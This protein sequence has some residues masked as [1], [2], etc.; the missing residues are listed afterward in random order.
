MKPAFQTAL[1]SRIG[2][3]L[4]AF[5]ARGILV[6]IDLPRRNRRPGSRGTRPAGAPTSAALRKWLDAFLAGKTLP[7]PGAWDLPGRTPFQRR[8]YRSVARI[9]AGSTR[10]YGQVARA[11]GAPG[12]ARAVGNAMAANPLP[13]LVPCHRVKAVRGLGGFGGGLPLKRQLLACET[14]APHQPAA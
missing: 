9:P 14:R 3:V 12:G 5:D 10:T 6:Q 13:L 1:P 2:V 8:V 4:F 11:C 7:F